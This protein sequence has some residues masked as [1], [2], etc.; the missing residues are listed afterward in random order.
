M[1]FVFIILIEHGLLRNYCNSPSFIS[2][3]AFIVILASRLKATSVFR[4]NIHKM[5]GV[6][7]TTEKISYDREWLRKSCAAF[8]SRRSG[9]NASDLEKQVV[10]LLA[11]DSQ[12]RIALISIRYSG[13]DLVTQMTNFK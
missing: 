10:A 8:A 12:S 4:F 1:F 13:T 7:G 6:N 5:K 9:L 3:R 11:S 2:K